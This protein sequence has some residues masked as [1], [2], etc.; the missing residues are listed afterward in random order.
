MDERMRRGKYMHDKREKK[1]REMM[2][3]TAEK[4]ALKEAEDAKFGYVYT[5]VFL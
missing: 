3:V 2:E 1:E 5:C 4:S